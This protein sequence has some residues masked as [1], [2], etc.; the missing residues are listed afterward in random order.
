MARSRDS[1]QFIGAAFGPPREPKEVPRT[2]LQKE[3]DGVERF[4]GNAVIDRGPW[5]LSVAIPRSEVL[6]RAAPLFRRDLAI[7][8]VTNFLV[9]FLAL[10]LSRLFVRD[11]KRLRNAAQRIADGDLSPAASNSAPNLELTQVQDAFA[12]MAARLR[13]TRD[14]LDRQFE[15]GARCT[16]CRSRCSAR[17][18]GRSG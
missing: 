12:D 1:A 10:W 5:L 11:L 9:L 4:H 18:S 13:D 8:A 17:W 14:A 6:A 3:I 16:R 7:V 2:L 15:Q